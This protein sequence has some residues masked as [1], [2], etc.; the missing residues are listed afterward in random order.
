MKLNLPSDGS[1]SDISEYYATL[2]NTPNK[3]TTGNLRFPT[4]GTTRAGYVYSTI[5]TIYDNQGQVGLLNLLAYG[6]SLNPSYANPKMNDYMITADDWNKIMN[7]PTLG[8]TQPAD[9]WWFKE[10]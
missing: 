1:L 6:N 9:G 2:Y 7:T 3:T 10:I 4:S 5:G 8:T